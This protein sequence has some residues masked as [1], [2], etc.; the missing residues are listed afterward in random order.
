MKS[1]FDIL[2]QLHKGTYM[3][4]IGILGKYTFKISLHGNTLAGPPRAF[5]GPGVQFLGGPIPPSVALSPNF[6][7]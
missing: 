1:F 2:Q 5:R 3:E 6:S 4:I 7:I